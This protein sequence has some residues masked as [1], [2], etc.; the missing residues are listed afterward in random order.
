MEA[1]AYLDA[2]TAASTLIASPQVAAHWD[3]PSALPEMTVSALAG[4]LARQVTLIPG[5][6]AQHDPLPA[7]TEL[8]TVMDHYARVEWIDAPLDDEAN[9]SIRADGADEAAAGPA[10]LA[11][12]TAD[13]VNQLRTMLPQQ[14]GDRPYYLPW[15]GW[16]LPLKDFL[17]TR[18]LEIVIHLDDL[19]VSV[20]CTPPPLPPEATDTV[21]GLLARLATRRHGTAAVLR[22]LSRKERAPA[23]ISAF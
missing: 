7:G 2:A 12:R 19:A 10:A 1:A 15:T 6:L 16:A 21:I 14:D 13:A 8:L 22:A 18:L 11:R 17:T 3:E 20:D 23:T 4:H 5:R 9:V